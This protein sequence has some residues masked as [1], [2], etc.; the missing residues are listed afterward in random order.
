MEAYA[1]GKRIG[2]G[3]YG[4]VYIAKDKRNQ[5]WYCLK[6]ITM[7]VHSEDERGESMDHPFFHMPGHHVTVCV[8]CWSAV[9]THPC[10]LDR[11]CI[12]RK[13][14]ARGGGAAWV[15]PSRHRALSR[16]FCARRPTLRC[17]ALLRGRRPFAAYQKSRKTRGPLCRARS[18]RPLCANCHGASLCAQ[19]AHPAP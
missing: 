9:A 1:L 15:R 19:Q 3:N 8:S 17:H 4:S 10:L 7:E 18:H 16:A 12:H 2:R 11:T 5:R 13:G 14:T 6:M